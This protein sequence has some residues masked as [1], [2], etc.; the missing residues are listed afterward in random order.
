M[1]RTL[2]LVTAED[3]LAWR[4]RH[5][6]MLLQRVLGVYRDELGEIN[7]QELAAVGRAALADGEPRSLP[8]LARE[9]ADRWPGPSTRA[10]GEVLLALVPVVQLPPRGLWRARA[11]V[12]IALLESW[13]GRE[14]EPLPEDDSDPVGQALVRR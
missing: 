10:L 8:E 3:A 11:G 4:S 6:D 1:R 5:D 12:R 14:V 13:L 2:H 7:L 9:L